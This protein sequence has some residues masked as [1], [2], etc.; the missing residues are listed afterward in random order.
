MPNKYKHIKIPQQ[1]ISSEHNYSRTISPFHQPIEPFD[2]KKHKE[3]LIDKSKLLQENLL[4]KANNMIFEEDKNTAEIEILFKGFPNKDFIKKYGVD[5]Y[6]KIEN[7]IIGKISNNKLPGQIHSDFE[8]LNNDIQSYAESNKLKSY[9]EAIDDIESLK[10]T[11]VI[12]EEFKEEFIIHSNDE[13]LIDISLSDSSFN[14]DKKIEFIKSTFG[15]NFYSSINT[16]LV[17][18]CRVKTSFS[19]LQKSLENLGNILYIEPSPNFERLPSA[20]NYP[21]NSNNVNKTFDLAN[22]VLI[23]DGPVNDKHICINGCVVEKIGSNNGDI[24]HGTAV[25]SLIVSGMKLKPGQTIEQE[26]S[27]ISINTDDDLLNLELTIQNAIEKYSKIYPLILA[28]LSINDY[29][30]NGVPYLRKRISNFTRLLD[31]LS[32]NNNCLFFISVG[33]INELPFDNP[34]TRF[35]LS[36]K[37]PNYFTETFTNIL[38]PS[39]SIN[40]ISVGS[41]AYQQSVNSVAKVQNPVPFTRI[42]IKSNQFIKPDFVNYDGNLFIDGNVFKLED[43]G[44]ICASDIDGQL[45]SSHGTSFSTPLVTHDAG[46]IHNIYPEYQANTIKALLTHNADN[47]AADQVLDSDLKNRLI[48]FGIPNLDKTLYSISNSTTLI[49]EDKIGLNKNKRIKIPIPSCISGFSKKRLRLRLTLAFNPK[50]NPKDANH[51]NPVNISAK[52]IRSDDKP[53]SSSTT[54]GRLSSAYLKSN[55]KKYAPVELSTRNFCGTNWFV[56]VNC[57]GKTE[58]LGNTYEQ[59]YSLVV[60]IEDTKNDTDLNLYTEIAQMIEIESQIEIPIEVA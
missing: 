55:I 26:N 12:E 60:T 48:G 32:Y 7:K 53:V 29:P 44:V 1:L 16:E 27:I 18:F 50:V 30:K 52:F 10:I 46:I 19:Y 51:Y 6:E 43:N 17:H 39:D 36:R 38:P 31:E 59:N 37:Y 47:I 28:N 58:D 2:I 57:E 54:R 5:I 13:Y 4:Q 33:N 40:N 56:E 8:T 45:T 14:T 9:F 22:P 25:A 23:F 21:I 41:I 15:N 24:D 35:C 42:N 20:M 3:K 49:V 11:D 34:I